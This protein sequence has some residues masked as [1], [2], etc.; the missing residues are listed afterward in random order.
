MKFLCSTG[1]NHLRSPALVLGVV[2][3]FSLLALIAALFSEAVLGLE[4]CMLCIYQRMPYLA[5]VV[6]GIVGLALRSPAITP[7]FVLVCSLLFLVN[8]AIASYHTGVELHWWQSFVEGCTVPADFGAGTQ[9]MLE[10]ILSAPTGSC[11]EIPW[12]DPVLG[13]S[14]ANYNAVLSFVLGIACLASFGLA[15]KQKGN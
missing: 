10:N 14:M 15:R 4:P 3:V 6:L 13:L 9:S 1:C 5:I 8:S 12:V 7:I 2:T 11:D